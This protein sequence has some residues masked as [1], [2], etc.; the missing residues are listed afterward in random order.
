LC[1]HA[2]QAFTFFLDKKSKQKNQAKIIP[3]FPHMAIGP[4]AILAGPRSS[5]KTF[6]AKYPKRVLLSNYEKK[7]KNN[8]KLSPDYPHRIIIRVFSQQKELPQEPV[9]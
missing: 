7:E 1:P 8:P 3:A 6:F 2:G 5:P 9:P 4:G